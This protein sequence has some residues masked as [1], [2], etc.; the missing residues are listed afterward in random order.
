MGSAGPRRY[1][2]GVDA[3]LDPLTALASIKNTEPGVVVLDDD[4]TIQHVSRSVLVLFGM[5]AERFVGARVQDIH[6]EATAGRIVETLKLVRDSQ[7]HVPLSLKLVNREGEDR[8][9]LVKLMPLVGRGFCALLYDITSEV[10]AGPR[11]VRIPVSL[12]DEIE[13][14]SPDEIVY[15][16][17]ENVHSRIRTE[18]GERRCEL[19]LATLEK[20]LSSAKF[21]RIH[22]SYLVNV[23]AVRKVHRDHSECTVTIAGKDARLPISR[24]RLHAFQV[25]LGLK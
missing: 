15:V 12:H 23:G 8:Y 20:R 21:F 10:S 2:R 14:L 25:A 18:Q 9:L 5:P 4:F 3:T 17:A 16:H 11:L 1:R 7:H 19:S 6:G 13:L 22:R 24:D